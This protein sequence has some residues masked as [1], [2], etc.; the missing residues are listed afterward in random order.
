VSSSISYTLTDNVENLTL[1]GTAANG[2]GNGL[3]NVITGNA[4]SNRLSG[5]GGNDRLI[6][7][8]GRDFFTGGAGNDVF[9][10]E[11]NATKTASKSGPIAVDVILDFQSGDKIDLSGLDANSAASGTQAFT[12]KGTSANK[13]AGDL[14]YKTYS[15]INGAEHA[16]GFD[17]DGVAGPGAAGPVT[18]VFGNNNGGAAD[19]AIV[20]LNRSGVTASDFMLASTSTSSLQTAGSS[21]QGYRIALDGGSMDS[22]SPMDVNPSKYAMDYML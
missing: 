7:G 12:F 2:T 19:F 15:S 18:V 6:G 14:T 4:V 9:V 17:I 3:D 13:S 11:I 21:V 8:D 1:T 22:T 16:L 10:G 5:G 20:L